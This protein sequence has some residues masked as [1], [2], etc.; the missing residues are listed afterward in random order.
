MEQLQ[1]LFKPSTGA[2]WRT[3]GQ[4]GQHAFCSRRN[5]SGGNCPPGRWNRPKTANSGSLPCF[6]FS[7][8]P[9]K[10]QDYHF[11]D[12]AAALN[13][14]YLPVGDKV[15]GSLHA[16]PLVSTFFWQQT[17]ANL[18]AGDAKWVWPSISTGP[19]EGKDENVR[20]RDTA[21]RKSK[22]RG[23]GIV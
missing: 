13:F 23:S 10:M 22:N 2:G 14:T 6:P 17:V 3:W 4:Y 21:R 19:W 16:S 18:P 12:L 9:F 1:Q 20:L 11:W 8:V 15:R 7:Q 5:E